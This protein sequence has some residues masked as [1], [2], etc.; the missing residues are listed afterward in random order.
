[1]HWHKN[2]PYWNFYFPFSVQVLGLVNR[3]PG[4]YVSET[5]PTTLSRVIFPWWQEDSEEA[6]QIL[7]TQPTYKGSAS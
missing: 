6:S 4:V 1:M 3:S 2:K 5:C 7:E